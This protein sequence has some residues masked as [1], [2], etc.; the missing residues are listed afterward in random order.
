M[1]GISINTD[2]AAIPRQSETNCPVNSNKAGGKVREAG[3]R[4]ITL[5]RANSFHAVRKAK[6]PAAARLPVLS[7]CALDGSCLVLLA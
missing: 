6:I 7:T 3:V 4:V 2:M 5:A 1:A